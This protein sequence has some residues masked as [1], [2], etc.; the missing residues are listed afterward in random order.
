M[1]VLMLDCSHS[2]LDL[3]NPFVSVVHE[4]SISTDI[5]DTRNDNNETTTLDVESLP[6]LPS[7]P[8]CFLVDGATV[9]DVVAVSGAAEVQLNEPPQIESSSR[10]LH[11][12]LCDNEACTCP[13]DR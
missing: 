4:L 9:L 5:D 8:V 7:G 1:L 3:A 2:W 11:A 6:S 12:Q 13:C 10:R